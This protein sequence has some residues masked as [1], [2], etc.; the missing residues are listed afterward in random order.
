MRSYL[1]NECDI[2][3]ECKVCR[4][5]YRGFT[6]FTVHKRVFCEQKF[7]PLKHCNFN[8]VEFVDTDSTIIKKIKHDYLNDN[9]VDK[10]K[11]RDINR[12]LDKL[13]ASKNANL[14]L[15]QHYNR[16]INKVENE[17]NSECTDILELNELTGSNKNAVYQTLK[18]S[19]SNNN[20]DEDVLNEEENI[21]SI[22]D[23]INELH[24]LFNNNC[25][26]ILDD[27]DKVVTNDEIL[28]NHLA[29]FAGI[30]NEPLS[31]TKTKK[32]YQC[33]LCKLKHTENVI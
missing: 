26:V 6:E 20:S 11:V 12:V 31:L 25:N 33:K 10:K 24:N 13:A 30:K 16:A 28:D 29:T 4:N 23:E 14:T 2:L 19:T 32:K 7:S 18:T 1:A 5:L 22:K 17:K 8:N 21:D 3:Y 9:N 15:T 27:D